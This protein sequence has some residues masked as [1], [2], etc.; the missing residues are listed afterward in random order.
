MAVL[1]KISKGVGK[2]LIAALGL[3]LFA[4]LAL[5]ANPLIQ[6]VTV[7]PTPFYSNVPGQNAM[8]NI[9]YDYNTGGYPTG[10]VIEQIMDS[11]GNVVYEFGAVG[12]DNKATGHY[13][14]QWDGKCNV[15]YNGAPCT[16]G[17]YVTD[18]QYKVNI[19]SQTASPPAAQ[20]QSALFNV[21]QTAASVMTLTA[22]PAAVY[23]KGTGSYAVNYNIVRNSGSAWKVDLKIQ[24][25]GSP[26]QIDVGQVVTNDGNA[27]I[28]WDGK[29]N[30]AD[31]Q[32]GS[33]SYD[34]WATS[35]VNGYSVESNHLTGNVAVSNPGVPG[36]TV[37][38]LTA[39]PNPYDPAN[40]LINLGYTLSNS[41]GQSSI[42]AAVYAQ[43]NMNSALK[44]WAFNNQSNG[45]NMVTWD[46]KD[47]VGNKVPD[48]VYVFQVGGVDGN[49]VITNQ[50]SNFTVTSLPPASNCAGFS[51]VP[52]D[53]ADCPAITFVKSIGAMTGNPDGT[54]A[55]QSLLQRDQIMKIV[56]VSF[57]Q[58]DQQTDY[59]A[60]VRP[61]PDVG[62]TDWAYQY[63]CR[64]KALA[65]TT[66][67]Q[68]GPDKG[69][70]RP[71]RSVNRIEFLALV[72]RNL[73]G[74]LPANTVASYDDV[75]TG[76]WF[77]GYAKY[78]YDNVLFNH[79]NLF[80]TNFMVRVEVAR[81]LFKL[82]QMGQLAE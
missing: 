58:F 60:G 70:Y 20:Y 74:P 1:P 13:Q 25:L 80:P 8:L 81:V 11:S 59:C 64:A 47:A 10:A 76:Q 5:A 40:G 65:I 66:G 37:G 24:S 39:T 45:A 49:S 61:F 41:S 28:N 36:S 63:V 31:A 68:S 53:D 79:P 21:A 71:S 32:V 7:S 3:V 22:Q 38:G 19:S 82:H 12:A 73:S 57:K 34:L 18:A 52:S 2:F 50:Q 62:E 14:L 48:G 42:N 44:S 43:N 29:I 72:L 56:L 6:N 75:P 54:F 26:D 16:N 67:Y 27:T 33:Y 30:N 9:D 23:Y 35:S 77:T 4:P 15:T 69:F 46:G 78:A 55:P 51:D 17:S